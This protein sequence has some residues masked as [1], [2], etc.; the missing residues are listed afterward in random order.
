M[1]WFS[2]QLPRSELYGWA[3]ILWSTPHEDAKTE[4]VDEFDR[5]IDGATALERKNRF[6]DQYQLEVEALCGLTTL[7]PYMM[8]LFLQL[9]VDLLEHQDLQPKPVK[10]VVVKDPLDGSTQ[11]MKDIEME[12][13]AVNEPPFDEPNDETHFC[14]V[15]N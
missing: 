5:E 13:P 9:E 15:A 6:E 4:N 12:N 2:L 11:N 7:L 14:N 8:F 10:K 1:S 3:K